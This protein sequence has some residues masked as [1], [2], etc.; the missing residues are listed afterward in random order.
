MWIMVA[1]PYR[2]GS[3]DPAVWAQNLR[4]LNG[5]AYAVLEKGHLPIVGVN[6]AL[7]VIE[8][9]GQEL[10]GTIMTAL[11]LRLTERCDA[12]LRIEGVSQGADDEVEKFRARGLPVFRSLD[13]IPSVQ[14]DAG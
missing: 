1:G 4:V 7:P 5:F 10:Y 8:C 14:P 9:A 3:S 2:S 12:I 11:S 6:L 13:E